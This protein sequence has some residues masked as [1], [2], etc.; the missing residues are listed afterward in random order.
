VTAF[1]DNLYSKQYINKAGYCQKIVEYIMTSVDKIID[2]ASYLESTKREFLE[3]GDTNLFSFY[4]NIEYKR[5]KETCPAK[6][7]KKNSARNMLGYY[8]PELWQN[9][10]WVIMEGSDEDSDESDTSNESD[11]GHKKFAGKEDDKMSNESSKTKPEMVETEEID[12][13]SNPRKPEPS[14]NVHEDVPM[15][16][17]T[18]EKPKFKLNKN[19]PCFKPLPSKLLEKKFKSGISTVVPENLIEPETV[20]S[21]SNHPMSNT[22]NKFNQNELNRSMSERSTSPATMRENQYSQYQYMNGSYMQSPPIPYPVSPVSF[23]SIPPMSVIESGMLISYNSSSMVGVI[24]SIPS[25]EEVFVDICE[26]SSM[27]IGIDFL[28]NLAKIRLMC[29]FE[30]KYVYDNAYVI[31]PKAFNLK[32]INIDVVQSEPVKFGQ[33]YYSG[34]HASQTFYGGQHYAQN[35][36]YNN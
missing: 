17:Q 34:I 21:T 26:L 28:Y 23:P 8:P 13:P 7:N 10:A 18:N 22:E 19:S 25:G 27:G 33:P 24:L 36:G 32:V 9:K 3:K 11:G 12:K 31:R 5:W 4:N 20:E 15:N 29:S 35:V 14:S 30:K 2:G 16:D 6:E 1:Y